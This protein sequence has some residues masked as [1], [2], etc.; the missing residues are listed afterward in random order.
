LSVDALQP[1]VSVE[2]VFPETARF[3]GAVGGC[4]SGTGGPVVALT[5]LLAADWLPAASIARTV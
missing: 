3:V 2:L 4:V 1:S 5:A